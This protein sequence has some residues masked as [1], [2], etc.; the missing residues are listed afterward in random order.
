MRVGNIELIRSF[1]VLVFCLA[2]FY[3]LITTPYHLGV[4]GGVFWGVI[5]LLALFVTAGVFIKYRRAPAFQTQRYSL[6]LLM[7]GMAA[8]VASIA[9]CVASPFAAAT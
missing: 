7:L 2:I 6:V 8:S 3:S 5:A 4:N 1:I 9:I